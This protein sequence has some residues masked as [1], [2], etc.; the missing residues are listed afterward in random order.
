MKRVFLLLSAV[1]LPCHF[2]QPCFAGGG[3]ETFLTKSIWREIADFVTFN[4][5]LVNFKIV[6]L[7]RSRIS[8]ASIVIRASEAQQSSNLVG[9]PP[10]SLSTVLFQKCMG[11]NK[12]PSPSTSTD[13][14]VSDTVS[15]LR[16]GTISGAGLWGPLVLGARGT[17]TEPRMN[18]TAQC[19]AADIGLPIFFVMIADESSPSN[20]I[21][22][23]ELANEF[24]RNGLLRKNPKV[25]SDEIKRT[26]AERDVI[27]SD[28]E[29][30]REVLNGLPPRFE[31]QL[32]QFDNTNGPSAIETSLSHL[33]DAMAD[34]GIITTKP[35]P[36]DLIDASVLK[37]IAA[38]P[39]LRKTATSND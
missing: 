9:V 4:D 13:L 30:R 22:P 14:S 17:V 31:E 7:A 2:S 33:I 12:L 38:D 36:A 19:N 20:N 18:F 1:C 32:A 29:A 37:A 15:E 27:V 10:R 16:A 21:T 11:A 6:A 34:A 3:T 24:A 35:R 5:K 28:D 23:E 39:K 8:D 25:G 26:Y